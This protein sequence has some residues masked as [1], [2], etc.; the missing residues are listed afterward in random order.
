MAL[1]GY[2]TPQEIAV[3]CGYDYADDEVMANVAVALEA[4]EESIDQYIQS[5]FVNQESA[6][7]YFSGSGEDHISLGYFLRTLDSVE[8]V[9][10]NGDT[11]E[12]LTDVV[13]QPSQPLHGVYRYIERRKSYDLGVYVSNVFPIGLDN[14]KITGDWGLEEIPASVKY[15][16]AMSVKHFFNLRNYDSTKVSELGVQ[17]NMEFLRPDRIDFLHPVSKKILDHWRNTRHFSN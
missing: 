11:V 10:E 9:D 1:K 15:A 17:R 5:T 7:K 4:V 14:I 12:T 13:A 8:I 2:G 3:L 16:A 6:I